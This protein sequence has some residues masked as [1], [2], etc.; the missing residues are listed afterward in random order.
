[1]DLPIKVAVLPLPAPP[2]HA[3]SLSSAPPRK[4]H[5]VRLTLP[6]AQFQ[7]PVQDPLHEEP[8][9]APKRP[10]WLDVVEGKGAVV[11]FAID[12]LAGEAY[13]E[14]D[15]MIV[16]VEGAMVEVGKRE[17]SSSM[18]SLIGKADALDEEW[19]GAWP[20]LTR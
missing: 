6:T 7:T 8:Q 2:I 16:T 9:R 4:K 10:A 19:S 12:P 20:R 5:L 1:M 11:H 18:A 15:M 14:P 13:D 17:R 3:A